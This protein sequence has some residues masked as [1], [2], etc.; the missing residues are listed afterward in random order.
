MRWGLA[1]LAR[2]G[3]DAAGLDATGLDA[4]PA[5]FGRPFDGDPWGWPVPGSD[6]GDLACGASSDLLFHWGSLQRDMLRVL[7]VV[8]ERGDVAR[9]YWENIRPQAHSLNNI[10][11]YTNNTETFKCLA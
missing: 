8:L 2:A 4:L 10:A 7:R 9:S 1:A 11:V 5:G 3:L 6:D